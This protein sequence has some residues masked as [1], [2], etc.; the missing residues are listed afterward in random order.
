MAPSAHISI[1]ENQQK[2][3]SNEWTT[4]AYTQS[5]EDVRVGAEQKKPGHKRELTARVH[6]IK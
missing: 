2:P 4:H 1:M 5:R 6:L 3:N